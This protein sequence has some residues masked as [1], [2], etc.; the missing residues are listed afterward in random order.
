MP[1]TPEELKKSEFY[2]KLKEQKKK[3]AEKKKK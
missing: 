1:L 3:A 2:Q